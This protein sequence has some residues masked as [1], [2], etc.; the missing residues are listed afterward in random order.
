[1]VES[2]SNKIRIVKTREGP[3]SVTIDRLILGE[4]NCAKTSAFDTFKNPGTWRNSNL[5]VPPGT[6]VPLW[7]GGCQLGQLESFPFLVLQPCN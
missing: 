4:I 2:R 1:M 3:E 5:P 7:A 6:P